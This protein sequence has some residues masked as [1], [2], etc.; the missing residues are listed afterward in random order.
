M[1]MA[2]TIIG[3]NSSGTP[4]ILDNGLC[5]VLSDAE[6]TSAWANVMAW[7]VSHLE[8]ARVMGVLAR[9]RFEQKYSKEIS[10][11]NMMDI[12]EKCT[13]KSD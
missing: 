13:N 9:K 6:D 8:D 7:M 10:V 11:R 4:E 2:L 3:T 12:V 5:G 1:A